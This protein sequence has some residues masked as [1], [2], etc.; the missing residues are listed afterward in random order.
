MPVM[1]CS[2]C[3]GI[4]AKFNQKYVNKKIKKYLKDG[5]KKTTLCLMRALQSEDIQGMTLLDIGGGLGDIQHALLK[6]GVSHAV[7]VEGSN[8]YVEACEAEAQRQGHAG[9]IRHLHGD[10]VSLAGDVPSVDI[11]TLDRVICCYHDMPQLVNLS[12]QKARRFYGVVYPRDAR[13]VKLA[14]LIYYNLR[15]WLQRNPMR[16][17]VHPTGAVEAILRENGLERLFYREMGPW[18]VVVFARQ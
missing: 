18:Q 17:F 11:V 4:E 16:N 6:S 9:R 5:P 1:D 2:Q 12:A 8:A 3:E 7:N 13:W 14:M 10:F 15:H